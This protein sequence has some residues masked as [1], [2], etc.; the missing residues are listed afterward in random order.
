MSKRTR[1][2]AAEVDY[3]G[4]WAAQVP[5][6]DV[7]L[8]S[9]KVVKVRR[10]D[11]LR[12]ALEGQIPDPLLPY[13]ERYILGWEQAAGDL[14][15]GG[16]EGAAEDAVAR[17]KRRLVSTAEFTRYVDVVVVGACVRPRVVFGEPGPG[18]VSVDA[19]DFTDKQFVF[20]WAE[21][22]VEPLARFR[23]DDA[24]PDGPV[25]AVDGGEDAGPA[26]EPADRADAAG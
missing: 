2:A 13:I 16:Q 26:P 22:L 5:A 6:E 12:M 21:G 25:P 19:I 1:Q 8:P 18:E 7:T 17:A 24:G 23:D 4:Q 15:A 9:G 20:R 11:V 10:P 3:E 14:A